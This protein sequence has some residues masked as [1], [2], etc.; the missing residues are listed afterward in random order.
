MER[1]KDNNV[2]EVYLWFNKQA[3]SATYLGVTN[4]DI[5]DKQEHWWVRSQNHLEFI[6][7]S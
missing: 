7:Y 5:T 1:R 2:V 3:K 4:P 6:K